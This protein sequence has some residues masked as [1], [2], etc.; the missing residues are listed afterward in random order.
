MDNQFRSPH[1]AWYIVC[2]S[3]KDASSSSSQQPSTED[4]Q[5]LQLA[6]P[7]SGDPTV[8]YSTV[9]VCISVLVQ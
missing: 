5:Q 3:M 6:Q 9:L 2:A 8:L 1:N 7:V 4:A